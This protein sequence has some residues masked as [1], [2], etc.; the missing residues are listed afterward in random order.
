MLLVFKFPAAY[1]FCFAFYCKAFIQ[2][3]LIF[4]PTVPFRHRTFRNWRDI[5]KRNQQKIPAPKE[6]GFNCNAKD[7]VNGKSV[8]RIISMAIN[9]YLTNSSFICEDFYELLHKKHRCKQSQYWF[10]WSKDVIKLLGCFSPYVLPW[11]CGDVFPHDC[12]MASATPSHL[13]S[14]HIYHGKNW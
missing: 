1:L 2:Q 6:L 5:S 10:W 13:S 3:I 8:L 11:L 9:R 4:V 14:H 12:K 7:F